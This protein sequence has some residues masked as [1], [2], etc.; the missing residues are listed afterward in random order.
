MTPTPSFRRHGRGAA[1]LSLQIEDTVV[2]RQEALGYSNAGI[3]AI[4]PVKNLRALYLLRDP[5][6]SNMDE[7]QTAAHPSREVACCGAQPPICRSLA[8]E[9]LSD[10]AIV[11]PTLPVSGTSH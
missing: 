1:A 4:S 11:S 7:R 10:R 8:F 9:I 3:A 5:V 6:R 2:P